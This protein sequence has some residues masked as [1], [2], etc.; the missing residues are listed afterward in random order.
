M[1]AMLLC[2]DSKH[3]VQASAVLITWLWIQSV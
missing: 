3:T 1:L 2:I